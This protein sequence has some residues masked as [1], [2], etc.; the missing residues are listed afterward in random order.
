VVVAVGLTLTPTPLVAGRLPGVMTPVPFA[1]TPVRVELDPV[2]MVAGLAVKLVMEGGGGVLVLD[3]PPPQPVKIARLSVK[4]SGVRTRRR[5][6]SSPFLGQARF[7]Q[8]RSLGKGV[9]SHKAVSG[10]ELDCSR[11]T[12]L[13]RLDFCGWE[14]VDSA[15]EKVKDEPA[16]SKEHGG[17]ILRPRSAQTR[18]KNG[19]VA[20]PFRD[21]AGRLRRAA[22]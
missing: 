14:A 1:K 11:H 21:A 5:F 16:S 22:Q 4:A 20:A 3:D 6:M 2:G 19:Q 8:E 10:R 18:L 17:S 12:A 7:S 9:Q 13:P 15:S